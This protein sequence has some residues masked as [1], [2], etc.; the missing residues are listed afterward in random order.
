MLYTGAMAKASNKQQVNVRLPSDL[1]EWI[2]TQSGSQTDVITAALVN[3]R[4]GPVIVDNA[5][6]GEVA[7]LKAEV[8]SLTEDRDRWRDR[9]KAIVSAA[10]KEPTNAVATKRVRAVDPLK[11]HPAGPVMASAVPEV[12]G[13]VAWSGL[14][15]KR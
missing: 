8:A 5:D 6:A 12:P 3:L 13:T 14:K 15:A 7:K 11:R 2:A 10:D 1:V 4:D 9:A